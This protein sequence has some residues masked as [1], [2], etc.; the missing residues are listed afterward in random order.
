MDS[1]RHAYTYLIGA[2]G[3]NPSEDMM[4][5]MFAINALATNDAFSI[6]CLLTHITNDREDK[7][8]ERRSALAAGVIADMLLMNKKVERIITIDPHCDQMQGFYKVDGATKLDILKARPLF[9]EHARKLGPIDVIIS[10]DAGGG[11][12]VKKFAKKLG[13][14]VGQGIYDKDRPEDNIAEVSN[15]VCNVSLRGKRAL[16]IDDMAD[17][18]GSLIAT[19]KAL[20]KEC[21]DVVCAMVTHW[22][23]SPK[24]GSSAEDKLREVG[25]K[26]VTTNSI[27]RSAAYYTAN[28][29]V[30][31]EVINIAEHL[32][33]A[34]R[35]MSTR[36]GCLSNLNK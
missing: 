4:R 2:P 34:I 21:V 26:V 32:A 1:V 7:T 28:S 11:K 9:I 14:H 6:R 29:D 27:P 15:I 20:D 22:I 30:L 33:K 16:I 13:P 12:R 17:T 8:D 35:A 5:T 3:L 36:G 18:C 23:G 19:K 24:D 10:P 31:T 25:L